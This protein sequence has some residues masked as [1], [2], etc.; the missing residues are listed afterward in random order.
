VGHLYRD[1]ELHVSADG[2]L[3]VTGTDDGNA[4]LYS[5]ANPRSPR[6][7]ARL[8]GGDAVPTVAFNANGPLLAVASAARDN[9]QLWDVRTA[10]GCPVSRRM[11][12]VAC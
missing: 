5:M 2:K 4:Y 3:L 8:P 12:R 7:L 1:H 11:S 6:L 9:V 10:H